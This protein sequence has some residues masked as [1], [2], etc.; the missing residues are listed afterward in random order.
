LLPL[1]LLTGNRPV[2]N[3]VPVN[4]FVGGGYGAPVQQTQNFNGGGY[5]K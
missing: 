1:L 2:P 5:G 3:P 4:N